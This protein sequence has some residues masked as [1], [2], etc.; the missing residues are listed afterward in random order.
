MERERERDAT[1]TRHSFAV[2]ATKNY[3]YSVRWKI[4]VSTLLIYPS[5]FSVPTETTQVSRNLLQIRHK[6]PTIKVPPSKTS[7][8]RAAPLPSLAVAARFPGGR[9]TTRRSLGSEREIL[10]LFAAL[11]GHPAEGTAWE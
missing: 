4:S 7:G 5:L 3:T 9:G 8:F 11:E 6:F 10:G 2:A 1:D